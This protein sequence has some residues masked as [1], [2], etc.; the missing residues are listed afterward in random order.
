M[1]ASPTQEERVLILTQIRAVEAEILLVLQTQR[2]RMARENARMQHA[3]DK[4]DKI[5]GK[6]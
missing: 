2:E 4:L 6:K 1:A 3:I 5:H